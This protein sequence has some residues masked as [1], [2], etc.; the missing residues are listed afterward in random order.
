MRD[1]TS[2]CRSERRLK[3]RLRTAVTLWIG[4]LRVR[5]VLIS[6]CMLSRRLRKWRDWESLRS[7]CK[8]VDAF[9]SS[10]SIYAPSFGT[11]THR[12]R[13]VFFGWRDRGRISKNAVFFWMSFLV[14]FGSPLSKSDCSSVHPSSLNTC[15][16]SA[17]WLIHVESQSHI[18]IF[19]FKYLKVSW[20]SFQAPLRTWKESSLMG[21]SAFASRSRVWLSGRISADN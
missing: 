7:A 4:C 20:S 19:I 17:T 14:R 5:I 13:D 15:T 11:Q 8:Q 10:E 9:W 16:A 18:Y 21:S 2:S 3:H 6:C 12:W 1:I